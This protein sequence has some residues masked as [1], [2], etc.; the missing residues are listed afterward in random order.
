MDIF[1]DDLF[2]KVNMEKRTW[3]GH[4][5]LEIFGVTKEVILEVQHRENEGV[6][7]IQRE[8]FAS[9][10]RNASTI[11]Y[12]V[13]QGIYD[14]YN[15]EIIEDYRDMFGNDADS[16]VPYI[17][18]INELGKVA[19][20]TSVLVCRAR[21]GVIGLLFD[22]TWDDHGIG[23]KIDNGQIAEIGYQDIVL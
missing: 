9:F 4:I 8:V 15:T 1:F 12:E 14:Y 5:S 10:I 17:R 20:L 16:R 6:T 18:N 19:E 13:E 2:G 23:V 3:K 22:C 11:I 21:A 7:D